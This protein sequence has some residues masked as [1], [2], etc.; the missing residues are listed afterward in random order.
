M[1]QSNVDQRVWKGS[2]EIPA[3]P[4]SFIF[5][6]E[7]GGH[8]VPEIR[9]WADFLLVLLSLNFPQL[10]VNERQ[11]LL[12]FHLMTS[13]NT[14]LSCWCN[15]QVIPATTMSLA[16]RKRACCNNRTGVSMVTWVWEQKCVNSCWHLS[17]AT[18]LSVA[19]TSSYGFS[20]RTTILETCYL[21]WLQDNIESVKFLF[22][23]FK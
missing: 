2:P 1:T 18:Q 19:A 15:F 10:V 20:G 8:K 11:R 7:V 12:L 3:A 9:A 13:T 4:H 22:F 14:S 5:M 23:F 6:D 21:E 16:A 17:Q